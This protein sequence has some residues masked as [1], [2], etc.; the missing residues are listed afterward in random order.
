MANLFESLRHVFRNDRKV[1]AVEENI[2][3][4]LDQSN[5]NDISSFIR[6]IHNKSKTRVQLYNEYTEMSTDSVIQSAIELMSEDVTQVDIKENRIVWVTSNDTTFA[7]KINDFLDSIDIN[8]KLLTYAFHVCKYGELFLKT[9]YTE[10]VDNEKLPDE[11]AGKYDRIK[12]KLGYYF[13]IVDNPTEISDLTQFGETIGYGAKLRNDSYIIYSPMDYIHI[14]ND[15]QAH[16]EEVSIK[17]QEDNRQVED[18]FKIKY[19]TSFLEPVRSAW[20][21]L[22]LLE[23]LLIYMRF[24][25]SSIYRI[26]KIEVGNLDN[27]KTTQVINELKRRVQNSESYSELTQEYFAE[28][29][30]IPHNG[31]IF[32]PTRNGKYDVSM[33]TVGGDYDVKDMIDIEY[34]R[35]KLF[36]ALRIPKVFLGYD[37][38]M[39]GGIGNQSLT[40]LDIRYSRTIKRLSNVLRKG[41]KDII[42]FYL[43]IEHEGEEVPEYEVHMTRILSAEESDR[44]EEISA[45]L[46]IVQ[47][48]MQVFEGTEVNRDDLLELIVKHILQ[49]PN[50]F[51]ELFKHNESGGQKTDEKY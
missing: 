3:T 46:N 8:E 11:P 36:A 12:D 16:R 45:E 34:F 50:E 21:V 25:M 38:A 43:T 49:L 1:I 10:I 22:D 18:T 28:D 33:D 2:G 32:T 44:K 31:T 41:I 9:Y 42:E 51:I 7:D 40:R 35:N 26:L 5:Y 23:N 48:I 14:I 39:P 13:E 4:S 20:K 37:E 19:G 15:S 27:K 47:S 30:P 17:F 6:D 29:K 24:G